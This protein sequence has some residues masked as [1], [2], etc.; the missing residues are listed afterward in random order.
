MLSIATAGEGLRDF[1]LAEEPNP[2]QP[3][4]PMAGG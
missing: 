4:L 3:H 1:L 2:W